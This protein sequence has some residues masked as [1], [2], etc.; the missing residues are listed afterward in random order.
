MKRWLLNSLVLGF[1][2]SVFAA[3]CPAAD[4]WS[5]PSLNPFAKKSAAAPKTRPSESGWKLP[6]LWPK[7]A[8]Q[9]TSSKPSTWQKMTNST[10]SAA[11]KTADFLNPFDDAGDAKPAA[12]PTG[13]GSPFSTASS[14]KKADDNGSIVPQWLWG[15]SSAK[16]EETKRPKTVNEFL[17]QPK[18]EF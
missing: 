10:K 15:S 3:S 14:Q 17:S 6:S 18:P 4:G 13:Y 7:T 11:A 9:T 8:P 2:V 16:P 12:S 5:L 1:V